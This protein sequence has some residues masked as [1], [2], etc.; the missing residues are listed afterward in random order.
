MDHEQLGYIRSDELRSII[1][2][3]LDGFLLVDLS[4]HI[5]EVN[6]SYCQLTGYN[7]NELVSMHI[8]AV[9]AIDAA[10]AVT[11]RSEQVFQNGSMRF[12]TKHR[13]KDGTL[14]NV[15]VSSNYTASHGGSFFSFIRD[16]TERK[17]AE[18][19]GRRYNLLLNKTGEMAR[20]GGWEIDLATMQLFWSEQTY[21]IHD[22][23]P[24]ATVSLE[25]AINFY[26]PD[27]RPTIQEAVKSLVEHGQPFTLELPLITATGRQRWVRAQGEADYHD[28][29]VSKI[30]GT[31][32]DI[33]EQKI[34]EDALRESEDKYRQL[35]DN[36]ENAVVYQIT[37]DL[38]G[39]RRF[40][41]VSRAVERLNEITVEELLADAGVI[42]RQ[43]LPDYHPMLKEREEQ[44]IK[45]LSPLRAEVQS[46]LPSG[47][48]RW[49]EYTTA[50]R[51]RRDG[52]LVWDG[53][54]VDI[55]ERK[56]AE[57]AL[58]RAKAA[59]EA[60][61]ITK[62]EFLANMSHE[63][64]TPMNGVIGNVQLLRFTDLTDEQE[65]FLEHIE[66]DANNLISVI[67]DV[68]DISK[69]EAG[70]MEL[71]QAPFNLRS[72]ITELIKPLEPRIHTKGL[73][74]QTE[75]SSDI[76]DAL[77]G[78]QL[79]LKQILRNLVGN[80]I[81]FTEKG[82]IR[83]QITRLDAK[84]EDIHLSFSISDTGI[85]ISQQAIQSIF[86]PFSQADASITRRFGGTG[87]GLSI[88]NRL[89]GMMGGSISVESAVGEGSTFHVR[90][91]FKINAELITSPT[92]MSKKPAIAT[93]EG[94]PLRILLVDDSQSNLMM[95]AKL[96]QRF[97]HTITAAQNGK[98]AVE[99]WQQG[100][101]DIILMDVQMP[102][103]DGEQAMRSIRET[104]KIQGGHIPIIALTAHALI[105]QRN[106]LLTS[107][108]D[109]YVSK[110]LEMAVL[111]AEI[112]RLLTP[113]AT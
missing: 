29:R 16:I 94:T 46:R 66:T 44:A 67:N 43:I 106:H 70:K 55:T 13:R 21:Q 6:N 105:E 24:G 77:V 99:Q 86:E 57:E 62:S 37:G 50:P 9:D 108:F 93:W 51:R 4:G 28:G 49:F 14:L 36:L 110:P 69:I 68:L 84:A 95:A 33:T 74:L 111:H 7:R 48:V 75:I 58:H 100:Q 26:P 78:D 89:A 90:L 64:R 45:N 97:G 60:A 41:Y 61:N 8:S 107:G 18:E 76:P 40:T 54:Q 80:A 82:F 22:L 20:I 91:P 98:E 72:S 2:N 30:F 3:S 92:A 65:R 101:F 11:K 53:I 102:V 34:A 112:G 79:R 19:A 35:V 59:A 32:Q 71:E 15:E 12:E 113:A 85:G 31:F 10:E 63:I 47:R 52:Q 1:A 104:E 87:L 38:E 39:G 81:K 109:G 42:Y 5:L 103:M 27:A 96:L 17:A 88:C 83:L 73:T 23:P 56:H 25:G